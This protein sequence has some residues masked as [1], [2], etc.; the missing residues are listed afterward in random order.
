MILRRDL[1][2]GNLGIERMWPDRRTWQ[3]DQTTGLAYWKNLLRQAKK[4]RILSNT[5]WSNW[6][7][8]TAF[9]DGFFGHLE[10][11]ASAEVVIYA[12]NSPGLK[13]RAQDEQDLPRE[14]GEFGGG[15]RSEIL[16][17]LGRLAETPRIEQLLK[18][19]RL[20]IR[21]TG[22]H[23]HMA[24]IIQADNRMLVAIYL[25]GRAGGPSP[26]LQLSGSGGAYFLTYKEQFD[27][28]WKWA[29]P[30]DLANLLTYRTPDDS[31][32]PKSVE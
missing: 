3:V 31:L 7:N 27:I 26:T 29:E 28:I 30:L 22:A 23:I 8:D 4:I 13:V 5:L 19:K 16:A 20:E 9:V 25:S 15:M 6:F 32:A 10:Q 18:E 2:D 24:Q 17:T 11:G 12:P 1:L 21:L 14:G